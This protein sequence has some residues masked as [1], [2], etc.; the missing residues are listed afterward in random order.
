VRRAID[1]HEGDD[2]DATAFKKL[3][4]EAVTFNR[5]GQAVKDA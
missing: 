2:V 1:I 3:V 4:R 5:D